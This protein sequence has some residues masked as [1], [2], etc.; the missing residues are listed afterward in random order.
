MILFRQRLAAAAASFAFS[1]SVRSFRSRD[2][3]Y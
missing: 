2:T 3:M 1:Q